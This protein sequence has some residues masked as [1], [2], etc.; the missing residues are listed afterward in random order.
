MNSEIAKNTAIQKEKTSKMNLSRKAYV[1][2]DNFELFLLALPGIILFFVF[3]YMPMYG[4]IIAF[5]KFN[6]N[7][8]IW[9]SKWVG[10]KNF[11]FFFTSQDAWRVTRNTV[12]Y[13]LDFI[14]IGL[15]AAVAIALMLYNLRSRTAV[16]VYNTV[17][18]L[19]K[20]LSMVLIAYIVYAMLNPS[21]G[22][23][24]QIL[25]VFGGPSDIDW[26]SKPEAWP[27]ILT[28]VHIWQVVGMDSIV[29]YAALMGIDESLF[30]SA[31]IDGAN[32]WQ[33]TI[34]IAIPHLISIITITTTLAL[35][36]IFSGDFGLF[37]QTTRD[38]GTLYPTTDIINTYTFRGLVGGHLEVAS[39]VGL[40][41][42]V[43]GLI[44]VVVTNSIVRK[45]NPENSL[46]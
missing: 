31:M 18:I 20:F 1:I 40:F 6:P 37:Y 4:I 19:P 15:I 27:F 45:I 9:G 8:G 42:S 38:V 16:K 33:Q 23:L 5:K 35:G 29:Y 36:H 7:L 21:A 43:V 30:E 24:N 46:F 39:A 22:L 32:K 11:E 12:L 2:K 3:K 28:I 44:L 14:V 41:Q 26:Y 10:F 34:Y 13:S 17:M 25:G